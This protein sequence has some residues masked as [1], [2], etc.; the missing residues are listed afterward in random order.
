[1][2]EEKYKEAINKY[3]Q[4]LKGLKKIEIPGQA[5]LEEVDLWSEVAYIYHMLNRGDDKAIK[6]LEMQLKSDTLMPDKRIKLQEQLA[7]VYLDNGNKHEFQKALKKA[8][9]MRRNLLNTSIII[10]KTDFK[11][12]PSENPSPKPTRSVRMHM[13]SLNL[14]LKIT[15]QSVEEKDLE[16]LRFLEKGHTIYLFKDY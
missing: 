5:Y 12:L 2:G 11:N 1:M 10:P 8:L 14:L 9:Q 7:Y 13:L 3:Q 6:I 16:I 4:I 15:Q